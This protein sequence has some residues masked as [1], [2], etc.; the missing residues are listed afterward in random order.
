[1]RV[2]ECEQ[3]SLAW[4]EGRR[5]IPTASNFGRILT[6]KTMRL[7]AA[8]DEY[9]AEL[10]GEQL[11]SLPLLDRPMSA[12]MQHGVEC[13]PEA[14]DYYCLTRGVE[15]RRVGLCLTD[16][17][18]FG[19]SPDG[20]VD[21]SGTDTQGGL[22]LKC[23]QGKTQVGYLLAGTL[24]DEYR[25]QVHGSLIVTGRAWWDFLSYSPG[26]PPLLLRVTADEYT[27]K[28]RA[29]LDE[30]HVRLTDTLRRIEAMR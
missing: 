22:E 18:R 2:I 24:P 30:F 7:A 25:A 21:V 1:M 15:V 10:I 8:A 17:G 26:L 14:R 11:S 23:P 28:L 20:L 16:D 5:G 13:E 9:I 6:P 4:F 12:A 29:A 3:L 27:A 19:C